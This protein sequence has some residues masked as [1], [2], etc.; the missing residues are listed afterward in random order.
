M[1][2]VS[3][4]AFWAMGGHGRFVWGSVAA[5]LAALALELWS[6]RRARLALLRDLR[7]QGSAASGADFHGE[8]P[9]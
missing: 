2:W 3:W 5:V 8:E 7:A 4:E 6:L 9:A 1:N